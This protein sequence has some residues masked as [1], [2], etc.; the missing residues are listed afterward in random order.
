MGK[1]DIYTPINT[2][3]RPSGNIADINFSCTTYAIDTE[4]EAEEGSKYM[5]SFLPRLSN[6]ILGV[7][8]LKTS[9]YQGKSC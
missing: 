5:Q 7:L 3:A 2:E 1:W 6:T 4:N 8:G 9:K